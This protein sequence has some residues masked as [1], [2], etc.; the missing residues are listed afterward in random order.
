ME[1]FTTNWVE[2]EETDEN[3]VSTFIEIGLDRS[4]S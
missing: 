3:G 2:L 1:F 4:V